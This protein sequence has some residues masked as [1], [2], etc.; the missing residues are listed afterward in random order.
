MTSG[1]LCCDL[2]SSPVFN[3]EIQKDLENSPKLG[4][5]S[6]EVV[7]LFLLSCLFSWLLFLILC[8]MYIL[9]FHYLMLTVLICFPP[10]KYAGFVQAASA[11]REAETLSH[12][13]LPS[14]RKDF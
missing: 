9:S 13:L 7:T 1:L 3:I 11:F 8:S 4:I 14:F 6:F 5:F 12:S 2:L 10:S